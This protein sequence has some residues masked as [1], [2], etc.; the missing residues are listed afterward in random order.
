MVGIA[1]HLGDYPSH[2]DL[3]VF[4]NKYRTDAPYATYE[5]EQI[6][7]DELP[8]KPNEEANV[9]LYVGGTINYGSEVVAAFLPGRVFELLRAPRISEGRFTPFSSEPRRQIPGSLSWPNLTATSCCFPDIELQ[10]DN[11]MYIF[12]G[13]FDTFWGTSCSVV[14]GVVLL[15]DF[16]ITKGENP[17]RWLDP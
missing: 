10:A 8:D 2:G 6:G 11:F 13:E 3:T 15:N 17:L 16:L 5:S 12:K 9:D 4:M 14:A 7:D 1:D